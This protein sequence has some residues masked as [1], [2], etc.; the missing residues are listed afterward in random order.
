MNGHF[1]SAQSTPL[2]TQGRS[3]LLGALCLVV[4]NGCASLTLEECRT[5]D[6]RA[7][8]ERD[9]SRGSPDR[10]ADH[11][12][13]CQSHGLPVNVALYRQ[14]YQTGLK[15]Y[16]TKSRILSESID[17]RGEI[18]Q[19]PSALQPALQPYRDAGRTLYRAQSAL[20]ELDNKQQSL[21]LELEKKDLTESRRREIRREMR[22]NDDRMGYQREQVLIAN[23]L[24]NR[25]RLTLAYF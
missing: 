18:S 22:Q 10:I 16:C 11:L 20:E 12:K 7:L 8:G 19:C 17:G 23:E 5:A 1:S 9:A 13:S 2:L 25:L 4:L 15:G 3:L 14:G 21:S 24:V 6:W